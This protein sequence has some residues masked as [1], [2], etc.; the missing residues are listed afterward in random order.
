[1]AESGRSR[2]ILLLLA[3]GLALL[4]AMA[5]LA[6]RSRPMAGDTP[7]A[8]VQHYLLALQAGDYDTAYGYL[9]QEIGYPGSPQEF[10]FSLQAQPALFTAENNYSLVVERAEPLNEAAAAVAVRIIYSGNPLFG[11]G[12]YEEDFRMELVKDPGGWRV[13][14][15]DRFWSPCWGRVNA[16]ENGRPAQQS[17][18]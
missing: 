15:G 16:C 4:A 2:R 6:A 7:E 11:G 14:G 1:M 8:V 9:A 3:A 5:F 18:G 13:A 17:P 10:V 12:S